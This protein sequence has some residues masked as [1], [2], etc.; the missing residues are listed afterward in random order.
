MDQFENV[1]DL[2]Q[3]TL[4]CNEMSG[5]YW[6]INQGLSRVWAKITKVSFRVGGL[7]LRQTY[8]RV[9]AFLTSED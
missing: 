8:L 2:I 4:T 3:D 7:S 6:L 9:F 1:S 5:S